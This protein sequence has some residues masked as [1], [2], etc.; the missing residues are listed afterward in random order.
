[1]FFP[2][3]I[4]SKDNLNNS[5]AVFPT[6]LIWRDNSI[7]S[8]VQGETIGNGCAISSNSYDPTHTEAHEICHQFCGSSFPITP[9]EHNS[10]G[11]IFRYGTY[12]PNTRTVSGTEPLNQD[13]VDLILENVPTYDVANSVESK[14]KSK[15]EKP[16]NQK[17]NGTKI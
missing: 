1:M 3:A 15:L 7:K 9:D 13:N 8:P 12:D 6:G 17:T 4:L 16:K 2:K 11:G 5:V 10:G 14:A